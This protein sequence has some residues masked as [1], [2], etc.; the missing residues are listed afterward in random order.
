MQLIQ[1]VAPYAD[2]IWVYALEMEAEDGRNWRNVQGILQQ[3]SAELTGAY[4]EMAF[5]AAHPY[6]TGL[7][8]HLEK[9]QQERASTCDPSFEERGKRPPHDNRKKTS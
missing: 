8:Q 1:L 4:R 5:S 6:W 7:R 3:R 2:T 9:R